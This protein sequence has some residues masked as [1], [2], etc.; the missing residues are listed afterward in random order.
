MIIHSLLERA[1]AADAYP[2]EPG[3]AADLARTVEDLRVRLGDRVA[4]LE[5]QG[6][7]GSTSAVIDLVVDRLASFGSRPLVR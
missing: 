6:R 5:R 4:A 3:A 7:T 2:F 1:G